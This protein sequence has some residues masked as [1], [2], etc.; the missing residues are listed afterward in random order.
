MLR[1]MGTLAR[2][3]RL[4]IAALSL[5]A[6]GS[7]PVTPTPDVTAT[8]V[9]AASTTRPSPSVTPEPLAET[10]PEPIRIVTHCGLERAIVEFDGALWEFMP[11]G[12]LGDGNPP[13]G[14]AG[15]WDDGTI[16]RLDEDH[17]LYRSSEGEQRVLERLRAQ[18][19]PLV[20]V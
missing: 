11:V 10:S 20:C 12:D 8:V 7:S 6:C 16:T 4:L 9:P 17:A 18:P 19:S 13:A 5:T 1:S 14:F 15:P 2:H 3:S